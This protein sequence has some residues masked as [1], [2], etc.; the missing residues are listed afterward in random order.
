[1]DAGVL[2]ACAANVENLFSVFFEPHFPHTWPPPRAFNSR[3]LVT[4]P[5]APH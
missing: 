3:K 4:C 5:H 2:P 1:L